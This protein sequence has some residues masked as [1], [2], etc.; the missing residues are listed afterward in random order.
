ME[1]KLFKK[2]ENKLQHNGKEWNHSPNFIKQIP[3][4]MET[5]LSNDSSNE[6]VSHHAPEDYE[7][8]LKKSRYNVKLQYKLTN[9]NANN[10]ANCE[11]NIIWFNP[12]FKKTRSTKI[13]QYFFNLFDKRFPKNQKFYRSFNRN[14]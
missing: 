14:S 1:C 5:R 7:K 9:Q 6:P 12:S 3:I 2:I 11:R 10:K 8:A 13:S 4:T